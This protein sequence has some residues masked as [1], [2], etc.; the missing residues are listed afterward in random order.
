M[1]IIL[2]V[3]GSGKSTQSKLLAESN[4]LA[5]ISI[6]ELLKNN[7]KDHRKNDMLNGKMLEDSVVIE[8]LEK[9]LQDLGNKEKFI[10]DGF[11][12]TKNQAQWLINN[13]TMPGREVIA[14]V[15]L[16]A[17]EIIAKERLLNRGRQDDHE[18]AIEERFYEYENTI[19]PIISEFSRA[20]VKIIEVNADQD[21]AI[22]SKEIKLNL[23]TAGI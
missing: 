18:K 7:I 19:K 14:V 8:I 12:R 16:V 23:K 1:I 10:L 3:A 13:S 5:W 2:G 9:R 15:H 4:N 22:V 11:P 6:G 20:G 21:Q 17:K